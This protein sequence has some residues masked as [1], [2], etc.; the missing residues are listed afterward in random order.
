MLCKPSARNTSHNARLIRDDC[1]ILRRARRQW[2]LLSFVRLAHCTPAR[3]GCPWGWRGLQVAAVFNIEARL[4]AKLV[5]RQAS[6]RSAVVKGLH[7]QRQRKRGSLPRRRAG[8]Q[9]SRRADFR[10]SSV[11]ASSRVGHTPAARYQRRSRCSHTT[12]G[13]RHPVVRGLAP[14]TVQENDSCIGSL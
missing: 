5:Q 1:E 6:R 11:V 10:R 13:M 12:F 9:A 3:R 4:S 7:P 2:M 14:T 8:E